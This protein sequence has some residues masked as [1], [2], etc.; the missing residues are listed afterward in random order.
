MKKE[1]GNDLLLAKRRTLAI[2]PFLLLNFSISVTMLVFISIVYYRI[3]SMKY[4]YKIEYSEYQYENRQECNSFSDKIKNSNN[5]TQ[6]FNFANDLDKLENSV[7]HCLGY[8]ITSV[9]F[10]T[11][12]LLVSIFL[13]CIY[14]RKSDEEIKENPSFIPN[15]KHLC[16]TC[17]V[18]L[19]I[20]LMIFLEIF[21]ISFLCITFSIYSEKIFKDV[22]NFV[23]ICVKNKDSF[24]KKYSYCW[25]VK[26]PLNIYAFFTVL[27]FIF[28]ITSLFFIQWSE[29]YN[30]WSFI[31]H[32]LT[33]GK[34]EYI[35]VEDKGFINPKNIEEEE[36]SKI[37]GEAINEVNEDNL[38][39]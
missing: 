16:T 37:L 9:T 38:K 23:D 10:L 25:R 7:G 28:D 36:S 12:L 21:L 17:F 22:Y 14:A 33:F 8:S 6:I 4:N 18:I 2:F 30:V 1:N 20:I 15:K 24:K 27:N 39:E 3:Y 32:K 29:K 35:E 34:Y 5:F 31:L 13:I 11:P 19:K 26:T